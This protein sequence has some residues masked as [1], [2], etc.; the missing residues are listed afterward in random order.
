MSSTTAPAFS[1]ARTS[2]ASSPRWVSLSPHGDLALLK[3]PRTMGLAA[4]FPNAAH[5]GVNEMVFAGA[6]DAL[7]GL[8]V[9]GGVMANA[10]V[11]AS[12]DGDLAMDSPVT[13]GASGAPVLDKLGLVQ[14]VV[15]RRTASDR[16]VAVGIAQTKA[17]LIGNGR[18]HRRGRPP[19]DRRLRL[20]RQPGR[21]RSPPA[22]R[23]CSTEAAELP[24]TLR[25]RSDADCSPSPAAHPDR[26][27][28]AACRVLR[29]ARCRGSRPGHRLPHARPGAALLGAVLQARQIPVRAVDRQRRSDRR[30]VP[31]LCKGA[32][33]AGSTAPRP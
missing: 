28:G 16:V 29:P 23:A 22:S 12:T 5:A 27:V 2:S 15:S 13:F 30:A 4:V 1:S 33:G 3:V 21:R 20:A 10:R 26:P 17:F 6:Y 18:P 8:Q 24:V 14:G 32:H 25:V 11:L 7:P 31:R 19:A 9:G